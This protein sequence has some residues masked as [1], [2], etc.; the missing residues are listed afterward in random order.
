[1]GEA[2][3]SKRSHAVVLDRE[4]ARTVPRFLDL[5]AERVPAGRHLAQPTLALEVPWVDLKEWET[6][7]ARACGDK[8][9]GASGLLSAGEAAVWSAETRSDG[10]RLPSECSLTSKLISRVQSDMRGAQKFAARRA[11]NHPTTLLAFFGSRSE[12]LHARPPLL[13]FRPILLK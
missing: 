9:Q 8:M 5:P 6:A 3:L 10:I 13:S 12:K 11:S 7:Q 4:T 1:M 2:H